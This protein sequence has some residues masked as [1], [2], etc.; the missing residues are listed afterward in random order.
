M[1]SESTYFLQGHPFSSI[2][3]GLLTPYSSTGHFSSC[4]LWTS[5]QLTLLSVISASNFS[6]SVNFTSG[7]IPV[8]LHL[9]L[10]NP[11]PLHSSRWIHSGD[12]CEGTSKFPSRFHIPSREYRELVT[13]SFSF[14]RILTERFYVIGTLRSNFLLHKKGIAKSLCGL[15]T[16][17]LH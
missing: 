9:E 17:Q 14:C 11:F 2:L 5:Q 15:R 12:M 8:L 4:F 6:S 7:Y 16:P 13:G 1:D 3:V 10:L